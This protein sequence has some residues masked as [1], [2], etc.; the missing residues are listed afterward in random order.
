MLDASTA[1]VCVVDL[2]EKRV[3]AHNRA[4]LRALGGRE[5]E[6]LTAS[7]SRLHA[8]DLADL[9]TRAERMRTAADG[10]VLEA[11]VRARGEDGRDRVFALQCVPFERDADGLIQT[12]LVTAID[13]TEQRRREHLLR[14]SDTLFRAF[15]E[16]MPALM[17]AKDNEGTYLLTNP[18]MDDFLG[19]PR[20]AML[21]R[22]DTDF[23]PPELAARFLEVDERVRAAPAP[24]EA[25]E[26]T[27]NSAGGITYFY[28]IKFNVRGPG[29]PEGSIAGISVDLTRVKAAETEREAVMAREALI[30]AQRETIQELATPLM[31]IADGVLAMPLI[32]MI[33]GERARRITETLLT[34][35]SQ[36]QA[37]IAII[38]ITG[39]K[40]VDIQV[41]AALINAARGV[42]LL[43][44]RVVVTGIKPQIARALIELGVDWKDITTEA[45]LQDGIAYALKARRGQPR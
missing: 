3:V 43:G 29:I 14:Q 8:R 37:S 15:R 5:Q 4:L 10:D 33:D 30:A 38:D 17:Y 12:I 39:V 7:L 13:V 44:A 22:K 18:S 45:T 21:G 41:A 26:P 16:H 27:P 42:G 2:A 6:D 23:F 32:G 25:E 28:S 34:G 24:L 35:I 9:S 36:N 19:L 31:P 20:D 1:L 40:S 11:E